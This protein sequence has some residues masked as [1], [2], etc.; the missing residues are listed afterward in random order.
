[1]KLCGDTPFGTH[2]FRGSRNDPP[3]G[4]NLKFLGCF[5]RVIFIL[6]L[7]R[8]TFFCKN[9]QTPKIGTHRASHEASKSV[10]SWS[11]TDLDSKFI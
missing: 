11:A 1:M 2:R 4:P 7:K 3:K 10:S 8:I 6:S 9:L 5:W